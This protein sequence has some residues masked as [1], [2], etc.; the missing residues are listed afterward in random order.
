MPKASESEVDRLM[1]EIDLKSVFVLLLAKIKWIVISVA[2]GILVF[3]VYAFAFVPEQYTASALVYVR[4]TKDEYDNSSSGT[5]ANNL[6]AAQQLVANFSIHMKTRP[7][8][9]AAVAKLDGKV[10]ASEIKEAATASSMEETSWLKVSVTMGDAKLAKDTYAAIAEAAA[11][12]F[13]QLEASSAKVREYPQGAAKTAPNVA[14]TAV[15]GALLGLVI[16]VAVILIRQF[17]D[18]TIHDKH[19]LQMHID[20]PVLGEIPS[21]A[22]HNAKSKGGRTHA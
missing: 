2:I 19:D 17:S 12:S 21:F 14:K 6:T 10:K 3:G 9:D 8:L 1:Q 22:L 20:V 5:T 13:D 18:N 16:S 7:V 11:E 15:I 4:N